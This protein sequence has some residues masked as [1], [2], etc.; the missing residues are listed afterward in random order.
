LSK[1]SVGAHEAVARGDCDLTPLEKE[2]DELAAQFWGLSKGELAEIQKNL[3]EFEGSDEEE[4][5]EQSTPEE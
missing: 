1:L 2:I 4:E 5:E 3:I